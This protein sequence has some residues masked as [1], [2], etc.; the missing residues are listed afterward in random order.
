MLVTRT[1][2]FTITPLHMGKCTEVRNFWL[3]EVQFHTVWNL[4]NDSILLLG[5]I[6]PMNW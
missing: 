6:W 3:S 2:L 4:Q 1:C 5:P